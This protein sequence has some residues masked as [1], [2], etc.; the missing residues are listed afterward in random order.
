MNLCNA[1]L[2]KPYMNSC[3]VKILQSLQRIQMPEVDFL[4][5]HKTNLTI[6]LSRLSCNIMVNSQNLEYHLRP[7]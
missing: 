3:N 4:Y 5:D 6:H 7:S 1:S 2:R